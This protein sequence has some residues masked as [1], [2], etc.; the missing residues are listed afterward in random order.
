MPPHP[1]L[2]ITE[3]TPD[4]PAGDGLLVVLV[5]G[6]L[7]R[8]GSFARVVRRLHDLHTVVYDRRGYHR[9]RDA[10]PLSTGLEGHVD[11]LLT[12]IDGRPAVVVGHSYGGDVALGAALRPGGPSPLVAVGA[13]EP[14]MPWLELWQPAGGTPGGPDRRWSDPDASAGA[15]AER[16]FR[17]MVGDAAWDRLPEETKAA[18]R[19]DGPAL[20]AELDA[21]RSGAPFDVADLAIPAVFGRGQLSTPRHRDTVAWLAAHAPGAELVEIDGASHGAHLTH[22]DAFAGFVRAT[23]A[24]AGPPSG[25]ADVPRTGGPASA[26]HDRED[27]P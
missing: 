2:A 9:S 16:F 5:H 20:A 15:M 1:S 12:V 22:P 6:S 27:R 25:W 8:S 7:D 14:P 17:R 13:Y 10:L 11:D 18:R 24:R 21:I 26:I 3:R 4:D 23:V 19:A